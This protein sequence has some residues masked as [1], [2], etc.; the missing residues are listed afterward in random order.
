MRLFSETQ[1]TEKFLQTFCLAN[2]DVY[3][4]V[5]YVDGGRKEVNYAFNHRIYRN[6]KLLDQ[7][8]CLKQNEDLLM[9]L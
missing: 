4:W 5:D 1:P 8:Q 3:N 2:Q 7:H 6:G 9:R